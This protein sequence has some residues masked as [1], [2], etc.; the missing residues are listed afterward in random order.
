MYIKKVTYIKVKIVAF[1]CNYTA[2]HLLSIKNNNIDT[3][4]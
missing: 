1:S 3:Y 4:E 2:S